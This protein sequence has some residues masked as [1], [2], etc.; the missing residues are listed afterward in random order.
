MNKLKYIL[1]AFIFLYIW[2]TYAAI[3]FSVTPIK[4]NIDTSTWSIIYKTASL[5]NNSDAPVDITTTST[6]FQA[7]WVTWVPQFV[8][9]KSELVYPE[10]ELASW[11]TI[12]TDG[13]TINPWEN[14]DVNFAIQVPDDATPGWHY[15]AVCF[16]NNNSET[17]S[18]W[19]IGINIDYCTIILLNVDWELITE[20]DVQPTEINNTWWTWWWAGYSNLQIDE[21]LIDLTPSKYDW[22]CIKNYFK[23]D[24]LQSDINN[25]NLDEN[26]EITA[27]DFIINFET[28]FTNKWNTH[29]LPEWQITL[30]DNEWNQIRWIGKET[31]KNEEWAKIW[32]KVVD[33]LPINDEWWNVLPNQKRNYQ[34]EWKWFPYEWYDENWKKVIKY[35]SPEEYYTRQNINERWL[36]PW[37]RINE[38]I[39][40]KKIKANIDISYIN[41]DWETVEYS[42]AKEF[43]VN[44]KEK[45]IWINPYAIIYSLFGL[46]F[47]LLLWIIFKKKKI[48]CINKDCKRKLNKDM[49]ICPYCETIQDIKHSKEI[50]EKVISKNTKKHKKKK[51]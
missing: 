27:N 42:S 1:L 30:L 21:C 37:E 2:N 5:R 41:K 45:Y 47:I 48:I 39:N 50:I 18:G 8:R 19:N 49:K 36:F 29:L 51:K 15:W 17:T 28:L 14:I 44:Y 22:K 34:V 24:D 6:D 26:S 16:K 31:I 9:K 4:Y 40:N 12:E 38:K 33:Y 46:I 25:L 35:W 23:K 13:F 10:Q 3:T 20:A 43:L 32:E 7:Y 11:I